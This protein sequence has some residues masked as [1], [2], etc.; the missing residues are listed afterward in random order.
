MTEFLKKRYNWYSATKRKST[1]QSARDT[2]NAWVLINQMIQELIKFG[3][4]TKKF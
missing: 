4:K 2:I 3:D 1:I